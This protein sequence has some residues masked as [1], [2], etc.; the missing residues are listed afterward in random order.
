MNQ[1]EQMPKEPWLAVNLSKI[2][3][4]VGQ[5]YAGN[6][7]RGIFWIIGNI[8]LSI[9]IIYSLI[10]PQISF[11]ITLIFLGI[12]SLL[13]VANFFDA[14][15]CAKK[16][17]EPV[18]ETQRKSSKD[19]WLAVFWTSFI[20][21]AG[22]LYIKKRLIGYGLLFFWILGIFI[23]WLPLVQILLTPFIA[24]HAYKATPTNRPKSQKYLKSLITLVIILPL[25]ISVV[26][27]ASL[28]FYIAEARYIPAGSMQP[29]LEINDRLIVDKITYQ[30][31][32]PERGDIVVFNP[33]ETLVKQNFKDAFIKRVIGLPGEKV[34]VKQG[35]V[36]INN[37]PLKESY[38]AD[39][40]NYQYGPIT[41][42]QN[43]YFVL[44]DNRN[45]SYDSH[46]WGF[47]PRPNIIG[48]AIKKFWP[49]ES[50]GAIKK[51]NYYLDNRKNTA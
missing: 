19:P 21:G 46:Y 24:Y 28:R 40:P 3:P 17:N 31:Q 11:G 14:Y 25:V 41:V 27:G 30:F 47:V 18:F 15:R 4:G 45:N 9:F 32:E 6:V 10:N 26:M 50:I 39:K 36:Y 16:A 33:T 49:P 7:G 20:L 44:G 34:E 51:V 13:N 8:V 5:I 43:E 29:T 12:Y 42:P 23:W 37:Q 2:F 1:T 48:K 35:Q 38:I 22:H